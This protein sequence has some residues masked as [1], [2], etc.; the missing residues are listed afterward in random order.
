[1]HRAS[2]SISD[3]IVQRHVN[4]LLLATWLRDSDG[5]LTRIRAG[6]FFG[7]AQEDGLHLPEPSPVA[8]FLQWLRDPS[9]ASRMA[10]PIGA[11]TV[12]SRVSN[13]D[14]AIDDTRTKFEEACQGF[15]KAWNGLNQQKTALAPDARKSVELQNGPGRVDPQAGA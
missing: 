12:G 10:Q 7:F 3:R 14:L 5:Q 15:G 2:V 4:A 1:M 11:L 9:T 8:R 6:G 13:I